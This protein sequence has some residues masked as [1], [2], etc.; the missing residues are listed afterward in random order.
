MLIL[1]FKNLIWAVIFSAS[2]LM[3]PFLTRASE[4]NYPVAMYN[5]E[6]LAKVREW[7]KPGPVKKLTR[8]T[9]T[10]FQSS[11]SIRLLR[12]IRTRESGDHLLKAV[13]FILCPTNRS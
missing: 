2:V 7:E 1:K 12:Y 8:Q 13:I 11:C 6:E 10:R 3:V 5:S 9:L 4:V